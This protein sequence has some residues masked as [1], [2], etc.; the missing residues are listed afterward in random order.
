M[1]RIYLFFYHLQK[2]LLRQL[3]ILFINNTNTAI[4]RKMLLYNVD[5]TLQIISFFTIYKREIV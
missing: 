5:T 4:Y 1:I 3:Y 2:L